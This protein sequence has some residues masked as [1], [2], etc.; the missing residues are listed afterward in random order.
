MDD[1]EPPSGREPTTLNDPTFG[2]IRFLVDDWEGTY[3]FAHGPGGTMGIF[4]HIR[5][6]K[7]GP[8]A[9]QRATFGELIRRYESLWPTFA[10]ELLRLGG[11]AS[12]DELGALLDPTLAI[13]MDEFSDP[14]SA[15]F[16]LTYLPRDGEGRGSRCYNLRIRPW[17]VVEAFVA[18]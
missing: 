14:E 5:A 4:L 2:A 15:A 1:P 17:R 16:D 7:S 18:E 9:A 13:D 12:R 10:R 3:P 8:S 6:P 11:L